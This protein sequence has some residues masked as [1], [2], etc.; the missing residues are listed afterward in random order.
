MKE[1]RIKIVHILYFH[2]YG[3]L[4]KAKRKN[5]EQISCSL[6]IGD[7]GKPKYRRAAQV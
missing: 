5:E 4:E 3:I 2:L 6:G 1:T 7:S